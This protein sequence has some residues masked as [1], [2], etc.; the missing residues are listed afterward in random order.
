MKKFSKGIELFEERDLSGEG[1]LQ[2][3]FCHWWIFRSLAIRKNL[4]LN[5]KKKFYH[6]APLHT[7]PKITGFY[8]FKICKRRITNISRWVHHPDNTLLHFFFIPEMTWLEKWLAQK[9]VFTLEEWGEK[10][11]AE[12]E[13]MLS[14]K[15]QNAQQAC[16][17]SLIPAW[18]RAAQRFKI[19]F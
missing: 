2:N 19:Y 13:K 6:F 14:G 17:E 10:S 7:G 12:V 9:S 11:L 1:A 18:I 3:F 5:L 8:H 16:R 4:F 15:Y